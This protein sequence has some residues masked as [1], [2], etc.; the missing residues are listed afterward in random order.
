M[1][2]DRTQRHL[3]TRLNWW[4]DNRPGPGEIGWPRFIAARWSG[5]RLAL[6]GGRAHPLAFAGE[7]KRLLA[8][9]VDDAGWAALGW[10]TE[11]ADDLQHLPSPP[12]PERP[13]ADVAT[14]G[15][16][17]KVTVNPGPGDG[18]LG[19]YALDNRT[20]LPV[21]ACPIAMAPVNAA[22]QHG[23]R[24]R[25]PVT[26]RCDAAGKVHSDIKRGFIRAET[27][28]YSDIKQLGDEKAVKA[29]G[30]F[31]LEGKEYVVRDGDIIN[32]RFNV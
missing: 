16:R 19:Y 6:V 8:I 10:R 21:K 23:L 17:N 25:Q 26:F 4:A 15:Y 9:G 2:D 1:G 24:A 28:A 7:G 14:W 18:F 20:V 32:F 12:A 11:V 5:L 3:R 13:A 29:A 31:R 27:F 22:L 30:K